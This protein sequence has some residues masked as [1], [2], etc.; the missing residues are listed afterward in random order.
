[1]N[2]FNVRIIAFKFFLIGSEDR[3]AKSIK[4]K[5]RLKRMFLMQLV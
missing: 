5:E 4:I 2:I 1:M 3:Q